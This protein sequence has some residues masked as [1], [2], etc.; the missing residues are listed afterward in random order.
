V[1]VLEL[2]SLAKN[3]DGKTVVDSF[4]MTLSQGSA[5]CLFGPSGSG[6]TTLL[7]M[8]AGLDRPDSGEVVIGGVSV[9]GSGV[10]LEPGDR[11]LNMVFQD[12]A[13]WPHMYAAKQIDFVLRGRGLSRTERQEKTTRLLEHVE[14]DAIANKMPHEMSGGEQQRLAIAR[15]LATDPKLLLLDEPFAHLDDRRSDAIAEIIL[16]RK[17]S[18]GLS[19]VMASHDKR[20]ADR[21]EATLIPMPNPQDV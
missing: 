12:L 10:W 15:A 5:V 20:D 6:K 17:R 13:L 21:L 18:H 14:L 19:I 3:F 11:Q 4:S 8:I 1:Y 2:N 7:R 9:S 16:A